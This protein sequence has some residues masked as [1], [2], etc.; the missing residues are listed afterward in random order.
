[1]GS[2]LIHFVEVINSCVSG[3]YYNECSEAKSNISNIIRYFEDERERTDIDGAFTVLFDK[4]TGILQF[5][6]KALKQD[7]FSDAIKESFILL[8]E[9]IDVFKGRMCHHVVQVKDLCRSCILLDKKAEEKDKAFDVIQ[10]VLENG[11]W[12]D[13][14]N[15]NE[16]F[17]RFIDPFKSN[18]SKAMPAKVVQKHLH[19]LGIIVHKYPECIK[20]EERSL[21]LRIYL[22]QLEE[23]TSVAAV[24]K[25]Q[26]IAGC[27]SGLTEFLNVYGKVIR[28]AKRRENDIRS[29]LNANNKTKTLGQMIN[30][31]TGKSTVNNKEIEIN[32]RS[33]KMTYQKLVAELFNSYFVEIVEKLVEQNS[34]VYATYKMTKLKLNT[35]S[36]TILI[37]PVLEDEVEKVVKNLK[38]KLWVGVDE[39]PDL[40][41]KKRMKS[42]NKP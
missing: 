24:V 4:K 16:L 14:L 33:N 42:T 38:G 37:Q 26:V 7:A 22:A 21:L 12:N 20:P 31:E 3:N 39:V 35:C 27:L 30:K 23:Q 34:E 10:S 19:I 6:Q 1:M 9:L 5:I 40:V 32:G 11:P 15:I 29:V 25:Y 41:V 17:N 13:D 2:E 8:K 18:R 28:E 36:E